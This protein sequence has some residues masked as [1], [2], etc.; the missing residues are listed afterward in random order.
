MGDLEQVLFIEQAELDGALFDQGL[1][2]ESTQC[3]DEVELGRD[4]VVFE[5]GLGEHSPVAHETDL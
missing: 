4:D 2:L 3:S 1:D 5:A